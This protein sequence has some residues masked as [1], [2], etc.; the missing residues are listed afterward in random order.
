MFLPELPG[1][2][3]LTE[4]VFFSS[5]Y[6]IG[7][8]TWGFSFLAVTLDEY[9]VLEVTLLPRVPEPANPKVVQE[10]FD[11]RSGGETILLVEDD[12]ALRERLQRFFA[13]RDTTS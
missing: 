10:A 11:F 6:L 1:L 2:A 4:Q 3:R 12:P 7:L 8:M 13:T 5:T 9:T